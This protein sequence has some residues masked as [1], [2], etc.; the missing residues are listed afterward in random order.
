[1]KQQS[2]GGLIPVIDRTWQIP[3]LYLPRLSLETRKTH[4]H[5]A[6][7]KQMRTVRATATLTTPLP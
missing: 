6:I 3:Y 7:S 2:E 5:P 1:M 4:I